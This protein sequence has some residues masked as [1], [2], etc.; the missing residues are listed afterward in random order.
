MPLC[1][2]CHRDLPQ[3][4]FWPF[5]DKKP[6]GFKVTIC[7]ECARENMARYSRTHNVGLMPEDIT[8][9]V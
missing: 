1:K 8:E 3:T 5:R 4:S 6:R 7:H 9:G 2:Q